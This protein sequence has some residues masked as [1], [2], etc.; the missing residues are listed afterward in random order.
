MTRFD[1]LGALKL[2]NS[3]TLKTSASGAFQLWQ[4]EERDVSLQL[5]KE[6]SQLADLAERRNLRASSYSNIFGSRR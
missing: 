4:Q 2:G 5:L 6:S 3:S 1:A